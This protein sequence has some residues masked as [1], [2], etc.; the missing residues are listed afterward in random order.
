ML[1]NLFEFSGASNPKSM[2]KLQNHMGWKNVGLMQLR[3]QNVDNQYVNLA[4]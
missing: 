1:N 3:L 4:R 2:Y